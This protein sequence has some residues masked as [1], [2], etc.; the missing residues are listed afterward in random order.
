MTRLSD[1]PGRLASLEAQKLLEVPVAGGFAAWL[2]EG[3][4]AELQALLECCRED[5]ELLYGAPPQPG[6][7][8]RVLSEVPGGR[9]LE[10]KFVVGVFDSAGHLAGVLVVLR[11]EPAPGEWNVLL[12]LVRPDFRGRGLAG[13]MLHSLEGWVRSEGGRSIRLESVRHTLGAARFARRAGYQRE[14]GPEAGGPVRY[15]RLLA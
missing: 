13:Q 3:W 7:A 1:T 9:S 14:P 10:D 4:R 15:V 12:L 6:L 11:D 2:D 5:V 8:E